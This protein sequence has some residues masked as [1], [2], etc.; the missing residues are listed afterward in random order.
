M[1][2]RRQFIQKT[3]TFS[4]AIGVFFNP[5]FSFINSVYAKAKRIL[6]P[7]GTEMKSLIGED[8]ADLDTRDLEIIPL[9]DFETMGDTDQ[10]INLDQWRLEVTGKV[11][12][13][14]KL[15]YSQIMELPVIER[16]VL[17]ICPGVFANQG[18]WKGI[19]LW[20]L[21]E[22]AGI[23]EG[24]THITLRGA[25]GDSEKVDR[26]ELEYV[27]SNKVFLAY[28][29]NGKVLPQKHGFPLRAVA[30]DKYGYDWTKYVHTVE[31]DVVK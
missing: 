27:R 1:N 8:P 15:T 20:N 11:K 7:R 21:L 16:K 9:K 4:T 3:L 26:F 18:L 25:V 10:E 5:V 24:T 29:V 14:Y 17:M 19:S 23:Q 2:T 12:R 30:E 13:P 31:A 22:T 6:V 28:R